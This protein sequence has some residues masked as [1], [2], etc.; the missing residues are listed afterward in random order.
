MPHFDSNPLETLAL[1]AGEA[2]AELDL[3]GLDVDSALTQ[4]KRLLAQPAANGPRSYHLRFEP[5]R[6]DGAETL[7]LPLGRLLLEARR[8]GTLDSCLPMP[9]G[10][11]YFIRLAT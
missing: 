11:G 8:T 2:E 7:F 6:G 5:A 4:V 1:Q 10:A 9:D 3:C